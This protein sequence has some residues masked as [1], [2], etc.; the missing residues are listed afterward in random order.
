LL[1]FARLSLLPFV[2][3]ILTAG[4]A[5]SKPKV[6]QLT[7]IDS[8]AP[9]ALW[10]KVFIDY[11]IPEVD[12]R[13]AVQ[14]NYEIRWNKAFGGTIAK[15]K[16]VL[17][18]LQYDL[19]DIGIITTPYH[20][21]KVPFFNLA[22]VTPLVTADIGLVA[23][24]ISELAIR[25]PEV[26]R[27]WDD[28]DLVYLTTAG[29][30]NTYQVQL[31]KP[32]TTLEEFDGLK[33]GGVGLNLRYL[34]GLGATG[35]TSGLSDW[36]N[37]MATGLIDGVIDWAEASVAYR[38]YEVAPVLLDVRLGAVTS[39]VVTV[40]RDTWNELPE[41]VREVIQQAAYDYRDELARETDRRA[42]A[43]REEFVRQGG[44]ITPLTAEQ[45]KAW[46]DGLPNLAQ[47]WADDLEKSG[48][49]GRQILADYMDMMRA[50]DQPVVRHWD[51]E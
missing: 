6:I 20:P 38:L 13:L 37:N 23:R 3:L 42:R 7:A 48:L 4:N 29:S 49:P 46:A 19:A 26:N 41:E 40:N 30:I 18:A 25:Y 9:T 8:Y 15:T 50:A 51:R 44:T 2:L 35:V 32:L 10:V 45:R 14:G 33:I 11:F 34:E 22:Y 12:R 43:S 17:D 36:Y 5:W 31:V 24:S 1:N 21:D 39:K 16:G 28:Y 27:V 47:E